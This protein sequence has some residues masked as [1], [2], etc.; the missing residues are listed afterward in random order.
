MIVSNSEIG[1][2]L[3]C[4]RQHYYRFALGVEPRL[5]TVGKAISRGIVGHKAL[6]AYY[7]ALQEGYSVNDCRDAANEVVK[8][9]IVTTQRLYP[10]AF[11]LMTVLIDLKRMI[12]GY[13][14]MYT[15]E[16][17]KVLHLEEYFSTKIDD[18]IDYGL[19]LDMLIEYT[20][21]P[22][23]GEIVVM[24]H[25]FVYNFK[26]QAELDSDVQLAKYTKTLRDNGYKYTV[27]GVFNQLRYR[28][29]KNPTP[30]QLYRRAP[31]KASKP[32]IDRLWLEQSRTAKK[33]ER[34]RSMPV[35]QYEDECTRNR[36][37]FTCKYC[38]FQKLC[39]AELEGTDIT[40]LLAAEYQPNTY[41]YENV[42]GEADE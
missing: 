1:M 30:D 9:E 11:D 32:A 8:Q 16:P 21:G 35:A 15:E 26:T 27:R 29:I 10:E 24:D 12:D 37:Q 20:K 13:A 14:D 36:S 28:P 42:A 33:I 19:R 31:V 23:R 39:D 41:G 40:T 7:T 25:K 38:H 17:F 22:Y 34:Y 3:R 5:D 18:D 4:E 2:F 6:N